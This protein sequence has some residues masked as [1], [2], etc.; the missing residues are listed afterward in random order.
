MKLIRITKSF[1]QTIVL[2]SVNLDLNKNGIVFISG[3]SGS[4][5][6]TLLNIIA[7]LDRADEGKIENPYHVSM[8]LQDY[9]LLDRLSVLD[10]IC[11]GQTKVSK[12]MKWIIKRLELYPLLKRK[13]STLSAGQKQRVAIAR[14]LIFKPDILLC[15]EPTASL[16][17]SNKVIVM[18]MLARFAKNHPVVV[19]SHDTHLIQQY[20]LALYS[21]ENHHL[22]CDFDHRNVEF[23][24]R[25]KKHTIRPKWV[26]LVVKY[27]AL[28][29]L[30][31]AIMIMVLT[32]AVMGLDHTLSKQLEPPAMQQRYSDA[33][34][35]IDHV[36]DLSV[37]HGPDTKSNDDDW[38]HGPI[39][40]NL[41]F[42]PL[43]RNFKGRVLP[44][45]TNAKLAQ[46]L[47]SNGL[48]ANTLCGN[49][50]HT[51][52]SMR[53]TI[54]G[55]DHEMTMVVETIVDEPKSSSCIYYYDAS[56]MQQ[57]LN[58]QT[59]ENGVNQ[60]DLL[61]NSCDSWFLQT[62]RLPMIEWNMEKA[63]NQFIDATSV[64]L[65]ERQAFDT[66]VGAYRQLFERVMIIVFVLIIILTIYGYNRLYRYDL[67]S[68]S[69]LCL[70]QVSLNRIKWMALIIDILLMLVSV[71]LSSIILVITHI[72]SIEGMPLLMVIVLLT[73][74]VGDTIASL[75]LSKSHLFK[76]YQ[77]EK[78]NMQC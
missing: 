48:V 17:K 63:E 23:I 25:K 4:G 72:L 10:N 1:G 60:W 27:H 5:K 64:Y 42:R 41:D 43:M 29:S 59:D 51:P 30:V 15:D 35:I 19:A 14:T 31:L 66:H 70:Y 12:T 46:P 62:I 50:I 67:A 32:M 56:R 58:D 47:S 76:T 53:Y 33:W 40:P 24:P 8:I 45:P 77:Q 73:V 36:D 16:D 54:D 21:I 7:K 2:D 49:T 9:P 74:W 37:L 52:L 78:G 75:R 68:L 6:T 28:R 18:D 61:L 22:N 13:V 38:L 11:L 65:D 55:M 44:L 20:A 39:Y 69:L 34:M 57:Y 71:V 26:K 3:D